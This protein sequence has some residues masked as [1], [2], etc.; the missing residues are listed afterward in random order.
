MSS[1]L[2]KEAALKLF[3]ENGYEGTSLAQIG[4]EIGMKKQ[5]IYSHFTS[6]DDLFLAVLEDAF[7][8]EQQHKQD[9]LKQHLDEPLHDFLIKTLY[10]YIERFQDDN[11]LKFWLRVSFFPPAH[12]YEEVMNYLYRYIDQ[13]D[14]LYL[15]RFQRAIELNEIKKIEADTANMAFS[16]LIDSICVELVYGGTERSEK[17]LQA[18]WQVYWAGISS[19]S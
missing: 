11:R 4:E 9:Y 19:V 16:A 6:K 17:K 13:V 12:L 15:K 1:Q 8:V 18:A 7:V 3:A 10:R 2:I 5:S 14:S